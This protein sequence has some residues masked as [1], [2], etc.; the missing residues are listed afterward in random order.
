M[1]RPTSKTT[2]ILLAVLVLAVIGL[3]LFLHRGNKGVVQ[4]P[5]SE[6]TP[7]PSTPTEWP[8]AIVKDQTIT[9]NASY[10]TISAIYP[11][12]KDDVINGYFKTFVTNAISQFKDD[13]SWAA[14]EG[15]TIAPAEASSLSLDI[16]YTEQKS[17]TADNFIFSITTYTGGAHGLQATKTF[18]FSPT[19]QQ[20]MLAALFKNGINGLKT[21][22]PYVQQQL[23]KSADA[24]QT[25]IKAG[26][27]PTES[28]FQNFIITDE[29]VTFIFDP[30]Q[31]A[32]YSAGTQTVK[33]P[34][35]AFKT[36]ASKD[37]FGN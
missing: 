1:N 35:S 32:P 21:V 14:G 30:Y 18:S 16:K 19:G 10:Y 17:A 7:V 6:T 27:A 33:V 8:T 3:V 29:G 25:A 23:S 26:A 34:L 2:L 22:A 15:A 24:D 4:N 31:V 9:D 20:I 37:V 5:V 13:T 11:V 36:I 28:N 12:V